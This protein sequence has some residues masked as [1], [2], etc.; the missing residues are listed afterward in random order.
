MEHVG[1]G[2]HEIGPR[3][4]RAARVLRRVPIVGEH[5]HVG[6]RLRQL[7]QLGQLVLGQ[8]LGGEQIEHAGVG[9]LHERLEHRQVVAQ[10]LARRC[11]RDDDEVLALGHRLEGLGLVRVE[12]FH[13]ARAERFEQ[14]RIE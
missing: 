4:H 3:A 2:E 8:R 5:A 13:A 14:T 9:L 7:H 6:Q 1:V 11:R 10:R 12:L